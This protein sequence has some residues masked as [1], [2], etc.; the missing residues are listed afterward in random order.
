MSISTTTHPT[1]P[2]GT[3]MPPIPWNANH[4]LLVY[5]SKIHQ[6][7]SRSPNLNLE[8]RSYSFSMMSLPIMTFHWFHFQWALECWRMKILVMFFVV[9]IW[10]QVFPLLPPSKVVFQSLNLINWNMQIWQLILIP[11]SIRGFS[12]TL[13]LQPLALSLKCYVSN[14]TPSWLHLLKA[15]LVLLVLKKLIVWWYENVSWTLNVDFPFFFKFI[16]KTMGFYIGW[17]EWKTILKR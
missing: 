4:P 14:P 17:E 9:V 3:S 1:P 7:L 2:V 10:I 15:C 16:F 11:S 12:S 5:L 8:P 13:G 6:W